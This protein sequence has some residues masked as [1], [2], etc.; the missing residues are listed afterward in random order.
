MGFR[1][2]VS[3]SLVNRAIAVTYYITTISAVIVE[4]YSFEDSLLGMM[5]FA[6][7][8][9]EFWQ[10]AGEKGPDLRDVKVILRILR[11]LR[12]EFDARPFV[13]VSSTREQAI[14]KLT[15]DL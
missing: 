4:V 14:R 13:D 7:V 6:M 2:R 3:K 11:G 5:V 1:R 15:V 12:M 9:Y 8:D 10:K